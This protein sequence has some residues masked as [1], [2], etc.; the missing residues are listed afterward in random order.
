[1]D[2]VEDDVVDDQAIA[3]VRDDGVPPP[4]YRS[5]ET[6]AILYLQQRPPVATQ[7]RSATSMFANCLS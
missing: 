5:V 1:V 2:E 6:L 7:R 4:R 3:I